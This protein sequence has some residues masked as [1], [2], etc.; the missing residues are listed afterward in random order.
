VETVG[1]SVQVQQRFVSTVAKPRYWSAA[2]RFAW[3][4]NRE[5]SGSTIR[6]RIN[7][8]FAARRSLSGAGDF[9]SRYGTLV[10]IQIIICWWLNQFTSTLTNSPSS[11]LLLQ[12]L[13]V[14][15]QFTFSTQVVSPSDEALPPGDVHIR[16]NQSSDFT[17]TG[18]RIYVL[19]IV[20]GVIVTKKSAIIAPNEKD[21]I[22]FL[23][24]SVSCNFFCC[25][26][27]VSLPLMHSFF[28]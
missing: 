7:L 16:K 25:V 2:C 6:A 24:I 11:P 18:R 13:K 21:K 28:C 17:E 9:R 3:S 4:A 23:L 26:H 12:Q 15:L 27:P 14:F 1:V 10:N 22:V 20:N 8:H 5:S 19:T